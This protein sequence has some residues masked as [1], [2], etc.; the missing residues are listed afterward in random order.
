MRVTS[1][2]PRFN[3]SH[4]GLPPSSIHKMTG[5]G[6]KMVSTMMCTHKPHYT[7]RFGG[8]ITQWGFGGPLHSGFFLGGG[9]G[10]QVKLK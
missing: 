9:G 5:L 2:Y 6:G 1:W 4:F 3:G 8:T 10:G 7:V